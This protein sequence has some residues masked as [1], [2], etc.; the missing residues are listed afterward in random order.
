MLKTVE[1]AVCTCFSY[2]R[3]EKIFA[4]AKDYL[5]AEIVDKYP[6]CEYLLSKALAICPMHATKNLSAYY[7]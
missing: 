4:K 5:D 3:A 1:L 6:A 7:L 2:R